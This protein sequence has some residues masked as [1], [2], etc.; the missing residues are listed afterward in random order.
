VQETGIVDRNLL[1]N[2]PSWLTYAGEKY[3]QAAN[4]VKSKAQEL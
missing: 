2:N 3:H 4:T 1:G